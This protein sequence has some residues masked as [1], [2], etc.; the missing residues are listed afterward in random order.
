TLS[1]RDVD[2]RALLLAI[3]EQAGLSLVIDPSVT[4]RTTVNLTAVP[5]VEALRAVLAVAGLGLASGPPQPPFG[6]TVFYAVPVDLSGASAEL[7][8]D[9]FGVSL[10]MAR[11]IVA[12]RTPS[13]LLPMP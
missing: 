8:R 7:I 1:A 4:G 10:E 12:N 13:L 5:A 9:R 11:F 2:V 3:A 6:A